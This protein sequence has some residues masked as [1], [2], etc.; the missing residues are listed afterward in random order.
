MKVSYASLNI[1][2]LIYFVR[3]WGL[4][5]GSTLSNYKYRQPKKLPGCL[6]HV[7]L[8][9]HSCWPKVC[10]KKNVI[11]EIRRLTDA[12]GQIVFNFRNIF[13]EIFIHLSNVREI[14]SLIKLHEVDFFNS[15][16]SIL[17]NYLW[18]IFFQKMNS[19]KE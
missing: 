2:V 3:K 8:N 18:N 10:F 6:M 12:V 4:F 1:T 5:Q 14:C 15:Y 11:Y 9:S 19:F 7:I 13:L 16:E 17:Q